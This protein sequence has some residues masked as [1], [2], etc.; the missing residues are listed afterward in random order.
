MSEQSRT[1]KGAVE[2]LSSDGCVLS[3]TS[4]RNLDRRLSSSAL[5]EPGWARKVLS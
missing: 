2:A 1:R 4:F 3:A 5:F